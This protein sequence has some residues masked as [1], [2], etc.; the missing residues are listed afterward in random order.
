MD[1]KK[2]YDATEASIRGGLRGQTNR[3]EK[4]Q[5]LEPIDEPLDVT[6]ELDDGTLIIVLP[7]D[8]PIGQYFRPNIEFHTEEEN[9]GT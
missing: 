1:D 8:A 9:N 5:Q 3:G 7:D 6:I 2:T 4:F